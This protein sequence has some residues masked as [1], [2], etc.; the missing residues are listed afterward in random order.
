MTGGLAIAADALAV[1][2]GNDAVIDAITAAVSPG[3]SLALVGTNGSGKSTLLK[4]LVGLLRPIGGELCVLGEPPG[5]APKRVAYLSQFHNS[6]LPL[7]LQ[8]LDVVRMGR[9]AH[10]GLHRRRTA[11]DDRLVADALEA[12]DI[13]DLAHEPLGSLSGGQRQR[14]HLAKVVAHDAD[15][16]LLDEPTVGLDLGGRERYR[17][18]VVDALD[19]GAAV[20]TATHDIAEAQ[21]CD[22]VLL[23]AHRVVAAGPPH[24]VLTAENLLSAFGIALAGLDHLGHQDLIHSDDPHAHD[25]AHEHGAGGHDHRH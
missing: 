18:L 24:V 2:Y 14:V 7:P 15:L 16:I 17:R 3:E 11:R 19:R 23:L 1:G 20:V 5:H 4:T 12:L 13:T 25:H 21:T 22:H 10:L 6:R 8:A 9:F